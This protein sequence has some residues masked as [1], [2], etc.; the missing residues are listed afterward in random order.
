MGERRVGPFKAKMP[1]PG[2]WCGILNNSRRRETAP[3]DFT[4]STTVKVDRLSAPG[5]RDGHGLREP[6]RR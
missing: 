3:S 1:P 4:T 6:L 5:K 2:E